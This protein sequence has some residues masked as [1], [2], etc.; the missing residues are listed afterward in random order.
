MNEWAPSH[1]PNAS[2]ALVTLLIL[3]VSMGS[4]KRLPSDDT[5]GR[6]SCI[7]QKKM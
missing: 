1:P 4:G 3:R 7:L 5:L 6:L 2:N